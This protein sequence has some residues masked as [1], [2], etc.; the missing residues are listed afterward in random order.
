M[1]WQY[2]FFN[3]QPLRNTKTPNKASPKIT[4]IMHWTLG[5]VQR[6]CAWAGRHLHLTA[7]GAV[8]VCSP[9]AHSP[10][11]RHFHLCL[12]HGAG[13]HFSPAWPSPR[14]VPGQCR[15]ASSFSCSQAR[16]FVAVHARP[17]AGYAHVRRH[18][19]ESVNE[20]GSCTSDHYL[21]WSGEV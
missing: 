8:Q 9:E 10:D 21:E 7:F 14:S 6:S 15:L 1:R 20:K 17:S 12:R 18:Q 16:R 13:K 11:L 5:I 4:G 3:Q 2:H 19:K